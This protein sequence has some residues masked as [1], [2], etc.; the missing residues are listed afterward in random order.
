MSNFQIIIAFALNKEIPTFESS[1]D[2]FQIVWDL[3]DE[4]R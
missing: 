4:E 3:E 2:M 1:N